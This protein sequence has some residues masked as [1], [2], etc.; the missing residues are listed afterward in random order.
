V[1]DVVDRLLDVIGLDDVH[2]QIQEPLGVADVL[3]VAQRTRLEVVH[4]DHPVAAREQL[5]A[6]MRSE[7]PRATG[8]QTGRHARRIATRA[9]GL[10]PG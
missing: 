7:E 9:A 10:T 8:D 4:A 3:D 5:V 6:E 1:V 2:T